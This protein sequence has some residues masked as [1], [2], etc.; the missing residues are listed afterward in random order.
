M[1]ASSYPDGE[2]VGAGPQVK[3]ERL[4]PPF[5][6]RDNLWLPLDCAFVITRTV[7]QIVR[8][9]DFGE[10]LHA[11][12]VDLCEDAPKRNAI[13]LLR[14]LAILDFPFKGDEL[15]LLKRS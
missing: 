8:G 14:N 15:P 9:F 6:W 7:C 3:E 10:P 1:H 12:R 2:A 11:R 4:S 5:R 13:S